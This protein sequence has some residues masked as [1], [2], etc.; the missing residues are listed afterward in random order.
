MSVVC[1]KASFNI[2]SGKSF[3]VKLPVRMT[4]AFERQKTFNMIVSYLI[5]I[6]R[7]GAGCNYLNTCVKIKKATGSLSFPPVIHWTIELQDL[8]WALTIT[9][10]NLFIYLNSMQG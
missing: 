1:W 6:Y 9:L 2:S 8:I 5:L 3:C 10:P 7:E 4:R